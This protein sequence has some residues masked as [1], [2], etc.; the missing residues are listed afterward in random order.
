MNVCFPAEPEIITDVRTI[1]EE[2]NEKTRNDLVCGVSVKTEG[3]S[4]KTAIVSLDVRGWA[5]NTN[6]MLKFELSELV[7]AISQAT[8]YA[9]K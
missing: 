5:K 3:N 7:S 8:L 1:D 6:L 4:T 2:G 9:D